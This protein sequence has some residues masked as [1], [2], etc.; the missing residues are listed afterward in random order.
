MSQ[1]LSLR[2]DVVLDA[3]LTRDVWPRRIVA[4]VVDIVVIAL[5]ALA[6]AWV[7]LI[8][9]FLTFG[10]GFLL[11]HLIPLVPPVYYVAWLCTRSAAT[12]GQ[13]LLG[14]TLR[15]DD[16]LGQPDPVRPSLAQ[17]IAWTVLLYLSF[18][19]SLLPFL[20][21]L[22]TRRHRALHDLL[23]GLTVVHVTALNRGPAP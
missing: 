15:Q 2:S 17:A 18:A 11:M 21:V 9:G 8:L 13:R 16:T 14:L 5:V 7:V 6:V 10:L 1:G 19:L 3:W 12:P 4:F 23:S 20:L 22:V